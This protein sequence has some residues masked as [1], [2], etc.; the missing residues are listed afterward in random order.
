MTQK[1]AMVAQNGEISYI[2]EVADDTYT[3]R[4]SY[5]GNTAVFL[6]DADDSL[7]FINEKVWYENAWHDKPPRPLDGELYCWEGNE[8][9]VQHTPE[10][11]HRYMNTA[12]QRS[13]MLSTT[14][15]TQAADSPLTDAK[16]AE[17]RVYRQALRDIPQNNP[18]VDD[19]AK[20]TWPTPPS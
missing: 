17:W 15:W 18:G 9:K 8:W 16:K 1:V 3:D 11:L 4:A 6:N 20:I 14:D 2:T 12:N 19:A 10:K 7:G 13:L 5:D